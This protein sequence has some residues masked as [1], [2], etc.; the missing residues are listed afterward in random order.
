MNDTKGDIHAATLCLDT[1]ID[2]RWPEPPQSAPVIFGKYRSF[3][4]MVVIH[5]RMSTE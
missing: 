3:Y 5:R 4:H 1:H 2:I